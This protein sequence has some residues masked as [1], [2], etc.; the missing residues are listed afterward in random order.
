M[1][2]FFVL[3]TLL[4]SLPVISES[5]QTQE[6]LGAQLYEAIQNN[7]RVKLNVLDNT[8][9]AKQYLSENQC[10]GYKYRAYI[11]E[12]E[13]T[14]HFYY[15][16][17]KRDNVI[18]GKHFSGELNGKT[19]DIGTLTSSSR[20]CLDL[21]PPVLNSNSMFVS[22]KQASPNEFHVLMTLLVEVTLFVR[23]KNNL[24]SVYEGKISIL[25]R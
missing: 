15:V 17:T 13:G 14:E 24:Y 20:R 6:R 21:G 25:E 22:H 18:I 7:N 9:E 8:K 12:H 3:T 2:A 19:L 5:Y 11:L 16:T 4:F 23:T 1:K 10:S